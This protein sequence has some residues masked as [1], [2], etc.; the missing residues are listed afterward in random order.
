V[1]ADRQVTVEAVVTEID[2]ARRLIRAEGF[3]V[4]DGRVIYQMKDFAIRMG[5]FGVKRIYRGE[6]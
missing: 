1:P 6:R 3:L 5:G 2:D 4:V